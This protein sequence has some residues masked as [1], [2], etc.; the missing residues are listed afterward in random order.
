MA[1]EVVKG[2]KVGLIITDVSM[3]KMDSFTLV[4][5]LRALPE[6]RFT[7]GVHQVKPIRPGSCKAGGLAPRAGSPSPLAR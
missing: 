1:L 7:P 5:R 3:P 2:K 6:F 4:N